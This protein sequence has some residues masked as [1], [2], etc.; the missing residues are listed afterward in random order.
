MD[1]SS[2][3]VS[4]LNRLSAAALNHIAIARN[5]DPISQEASWKALVGL[6]LPPTLA[7]ESRIRAKLRLGN[8][9]ECGSAPDLVGKLKQGSLGFDMGRGLLGGYLHGC[10]WSDSL[11]EIRSMRRHHLHHQGPFLEASRSR[12]S[13]C[14]TDAQYQS[15]YLQLRQSILSM[16]TRQ[17]KVAALLWLDPHDA[18]GLLTAPEMARAGEVLTCP[19]RRVGLGQSQVARI[20]QVAD[21]T[22]SREVAKIHQG[23]AACFADT[24]DWSNI[25]M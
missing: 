7:L 1:T 4:T 8:S 20:L 16:P 5:G 17:A 25:S 18:A 14:K 15:A 9:P 6:V 2:D 24:C 12:M 13:R 3:L 11:D 23:I 10:L 22:V 21:A 19:A